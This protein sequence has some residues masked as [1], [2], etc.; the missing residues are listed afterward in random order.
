MADLPP[1]YNTIS[2]IGMPGAGKST[3]GVL[4]AKLAGLA[5]NDTDLAIQ[6]AAGA[7]LQEIIDSRGHLALRAIEQDILLSVPL[8]NSVIATGG[9][10]VYSDAVMQRLRGAGPVI[11]LKVDLDTLSRRV[12]A[13]PPRGIASGAG[14]G[15][16]DVFHER[17]PLYER[18]ADIIVES[19]HRDPQQVALDIY[20]QLQR[21]IGRKTCPDMSA[22][23]TG[24][25][26]DPAPADK[27]GP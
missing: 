3:V 13:A 7:T 11:Y 25:Y 27:A 1:R 21:P 26:R 10:V 9:S 23:D 8:E 6:V 15:Y 5:F 17:T 22:A 14:M 18:F 24:H 20:T 4:L 12:A 16:A 2:L 19:S